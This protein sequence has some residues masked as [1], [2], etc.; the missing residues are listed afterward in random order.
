VTA[1]TVAL[2]RPD[3]VR[4]L[5][6]ISGVHHRDGLHRGEVIAREVSR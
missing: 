5:V 2:A 1:L 3:L 6:L 4:R